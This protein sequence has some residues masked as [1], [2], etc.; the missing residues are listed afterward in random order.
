MRKSVLDRDEVVASLKSIIAEV[1]TKSGNDVP[2]VIGQLDD[3]IKKL[4]RLTFENASFSLSGEWEVALNAIKGRMIAA[5]FSPVSVRI[6]A[7]QKRYR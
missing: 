2:V 3:V 6:A 5:G 1:R 7:L 4:N